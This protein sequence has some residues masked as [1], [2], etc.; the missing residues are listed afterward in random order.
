MVSSQMFWLTFHC[1]KMYVIANLWYF[2]IYWIY[3]FIDVIA[4]IIFSMDESFILFYFLIWGKYAFLSVSQEV[5]GQI[6]EDIKGQG[7]NAKPGK[8]NVFWLHI[9]QLCKCCLCHMF[10]FFQFCMFYWLFVYVHMCIELDFCWF[11]C[12][13]F[14]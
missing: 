13:H 4:C 10:V 3:D 6:L 11:D 5:G 14:Q 8:T 9:F 7:W 2:F 12:F 1:E